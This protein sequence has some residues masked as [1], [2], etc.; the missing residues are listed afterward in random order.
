VTTGAIDAPIRVQAAVIGSGQAGP[1]LAAALA[2]DGES[3]AIFEG[4]LIGGTCVNTGCTPTKTLRK[5]ARVAHLARRAADFGVHVGDVTV[6][7]SAAMERAA[8]MASASRSSV[9]R[10]M[11]S[12]PNVTLVRAWAALTGRDGAAFVVRAGD[13]TYVAD[14]VYLNVG[15]RAAVP[16][17]PGL[18]DALPLLNDSLLALRE[19]PPQL[20]IVGG[21]YIGIELGQIFRRLGSEVTIIEGSA[22]I[23]SRE[24]ADVSARLASILEA[25]GIRIVTNAS[26]LGVTG[27][28]G[29]R[30]TVRGTAG[31]THDAFEITG[32][33]LLVATGRRPNTDSLGLESIG[34]TRDTQGYVPVNGVLETNVAGVFALG[35]VNRR[36][37]FTHTSWQDH[38]I[39]LAN[40]RGGS[41]SVDN[42]VPTYALYSDPPLGR[43]GLSETDARQLA[44][45]GRTFLIATHEMRLVSR[46]KEEGETDGII[47]VIV[48]AAT[49]RFVGATV[50]GLGGDEIVQVISA[51]MAADAP[52]EV[53]RDFLPVHPTVT[54]F[55]PTILGKLRPL[56]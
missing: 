20:V 24:D 34:V 12:T 51:L 10:W 30:V 45:T 2:G 1:A 32:S 25:E 46:A 48:D 7:F 21:S 27:Q 23:V 11:E 50:F 16:S 15:T 35:D 47:K 29:A 19:L 33:H 49:H 26:V 5:S 31:A 18:A 14:R 40:H 28:S 6:D 4:G 39:A 9:T 13:A 55:F 56:V 17:M 52:F 3:V 22:A 37:A 41:R 53:L 44:N 42:R 38:E 8:A 54:E 36:G 43:V